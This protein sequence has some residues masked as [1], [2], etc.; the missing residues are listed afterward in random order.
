MPQLDEIYQSRRASF[1]AQRKAIEQ[2]VLAVSWIRVI[3]VLAAIVLAWFAFKVVALWAFSLLAALAFPW[4]V[5]EHA[6]LNIR[7]KLLENLALINE[8]ELQALNGDYASFPD[9]AEFVDARHPY[10]LD[11]DIFGAG[12]L[13]QRFNRTCTEQGR[14]RLANMLASPLQS[15]PAIK[16]RRAAV[17]ELTEKLDFRQAFQA[18]GMASAERMSDQQEI[19]DWLK[20]PDFIY[21]NKRRQWMLVALPVASLIALTYWVIAGLA[22]P[23]I[24]VAL[25]QWAIVGSSAKRTM[26][27][28]DYLGKKRYLLE[29]FASHFELLSR[30]KFA[31][32]LAQRMNSESQQARDEIAR[33]VTRVRAL[34]LRLNIFAGILLNSLVLYDWLCIYR[35]EQWRHRNRD[36]MKDW[37]D[38]I[39]EAD[40]FN[41]FAAYAF[42]HPDFTWPELTEEWKLEGEQVGHPLLKN[43][44]CIR[45][46]I[47]MDETS[48]L[49][50]I[51]GANMAGKSTFLRSVGVNVVL[52]LTG[53][54]V[55]AERFTCPVLEIHSGMRNT[56]SITDHQS[57]FYAELYRLQG[58]VRKLEENRRMLILL[59][60]ILKGTNSTDKL[61]GS[62]ALV[63][64][65]VKYPCFTLIATHDV[66]LGD[67]EQDHP[68]I[69]NYHFESRIEH[70]ELCFDYLLRPGVSTSKNATFLMQKMGIIPS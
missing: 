61:S 60:E 13:F 34:D 5:R 48:S 41:S 27:I 11:L 8:R 30:Q 52:A 6:R 59:D 45:N 16:E 12:S 36:R 18:I 65:L 53:S 67:M 68:S 42:N 44:E 56:D 29:K 57:Y 40:A 7:H 28:Q 62:R 50:I 19:L 55:C 43:E 21:G 20:L 39:A 14:E 38:M 23:F 46:D 9:G 24:V 69:R 35:L 15:L 51:T 37:F 2:R 47:S 54:V 3:L 32:A 58:I 31:S 1:E 17:A 63:S 26:Q 25:L 10:T 49:W 4:F 66:A 22:G 64:R 70:G 33:L